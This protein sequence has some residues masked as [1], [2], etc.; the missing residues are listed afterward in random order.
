MDNILKAEQKMWISTLIALIWKIKT[1][2][3]NIDGFCD[4]SIA[5]ILHQLVTMGKVLVLWTF[6]VVLKWKLLHNY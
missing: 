2:F 3:E 4:E 5:N 6:Q 1:F